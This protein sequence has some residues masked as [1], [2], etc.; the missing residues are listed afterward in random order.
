MVNNKSNLGFVL[1]LIFVFSDYLS[2]SSRITFPPPGGGPLP[3][4]SGVRMG[5][6]PLPGP[7]GV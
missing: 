5:G 4:P 1:S 2:D 7:S 3:G 6:G